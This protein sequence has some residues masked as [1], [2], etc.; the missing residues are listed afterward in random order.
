[1]GLVTGGLFSQID[2]EKVVHK[3]LTIMGSANYK[4]WVMPKV[5]EFLSRTREKYPFD[6]LV[7]HKFRLEDANEGIQQS[8]AGKVVRAGLV[9]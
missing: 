6:K 4:P 9:M 5:L 7:S 3:G 1:M 2:M 8:L